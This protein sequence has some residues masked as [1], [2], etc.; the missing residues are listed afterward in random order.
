MAQK[1]ILVM[2][3]EPT[4][5]RLVQNSLGET[6]YQVVSRGDTSEKLRAVLDKECPDL[7]ILDLMMPRLDGIESC[8]L[9]RQWF[10]LPIIMLSTWG[11]GKDK[12][13]GLDLSADGYLTEPFGT[14]GLMAWIKKALSGC[15]S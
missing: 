11:A 4:L 12:V 10:Q 1:K 5:P 6:S 14:A 7:V 2:S 9:L 15:V 13:R 3:S 8:L